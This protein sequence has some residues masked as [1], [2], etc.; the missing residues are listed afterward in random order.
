M[1]GDA[2]KLFAVL[3]IAIISSVVLA[4][5]FWPQIQK[6]ESQ[7]FAACSPCGEERVKLE[8]LNYPTTLVADQNVFDGVRIRLCNCRA[9]K[10][11]LSAARISY[12]VE[13]P[14]GT[15]RC[16]KSYLL[17]KNKDGGGPLV[18]SLEPQE[19]VKF[20]W[21]EMAPEA[22]KVLISRPGCDPAQIPN[23]E[24][25][26][27]GRVALSLFVGGVKEGDDY[28]WSVFYAPIC[29]GTCKSKFGGYYCPLGEAELGVLN[30]GT[31]KR[32][33]K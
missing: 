11:G 24:E 19:G 14:A 30:C 2:Q 10:V 3:V 33:C 18:P 9:E 20:D 15:P 7:R 23:L 17:P 4:V 5:I 28:V 31:D 12:T 25:S 29:P 26:A 1:R 21:Y 27:S 8:A 13:L 32:C 16:S 22:D 6:W